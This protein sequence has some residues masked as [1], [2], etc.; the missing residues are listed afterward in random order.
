MSLEVTSVFV[1]I[2]FALKWKRR[3]P[4]HNW[5]VGYVYEIWGF[6]AVKIWIAV[7]WVMRPCSLVGDCHL[8]PTRQHGFITQNI[9]IEIF[10]YVCSSG[11]LIPQNKS[12]LRTRVL[13]CYLQYPL[14]HEFKFNPILIDAKIDS[15]EKGHDYTKVDQVLLCTTPKHVS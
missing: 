14:P 2:S 13:L 1:Q 7:F 11:Y 5:K 4:T 9:I 12:R 10:F 8:P 3:R 15:T 6:Q